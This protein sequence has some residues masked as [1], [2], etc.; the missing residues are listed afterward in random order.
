MP[1]R[2]QHRVHYSG[3]TP[4]YLDAFSDNV[5]EVWSA[6][7]FPE[8]L[9]KLEENNVLWGVVKHFSQIDLSDEALGENA[10]GNLFEHLMYRSFS[11]NG[12]VA[13]EFYTPATPS[14]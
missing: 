10:M 4:T 2:H 7:M 13:G 9:T 14:A 8:L 6:F 12:Q 11:E 3:D 5:R 1:N